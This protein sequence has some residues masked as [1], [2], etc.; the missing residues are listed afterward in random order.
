MGRMAE[1]VGRA[2]AAFSSGRSRPLEFRLQQL[3]NLERMVQEKER[4]ILA[5]IG[6]D[7][8]KVWGLGFSLTGRGGPELCEP[9][10]A[11]SSCWGQGW[12]WAG[13]KVPSDPGFPRRVHRV[14]ELGAFPAVPDPCRCSA[15]AT[16]TATRSWGCWGSW[17]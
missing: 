10:G 6:A 4:E 13:F 5:A 3:K 11:Q 9:Q 17:P 1:V 15:V 2:R 8:H 14:G 7:L 12:G 16:P